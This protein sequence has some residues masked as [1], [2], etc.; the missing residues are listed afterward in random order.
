MERQ[1]PSPIAPD[2]GAADNRHVRFLSEPLRGHPVHDDAAVGRQLHDLRVDKIEARP[3]GATSIASIA[4]CLD[5]TPKGKGRQHI[6]R[7]VRAT[8][9]AATAGCQYLPALPIGIDQL[10]C[11]LTH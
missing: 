7:Q 3:R 11:E 2:K 8:V 9:L 10:L 1:Q 5:T 4:S 6:G